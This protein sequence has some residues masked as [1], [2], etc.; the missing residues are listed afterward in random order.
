MIQV[1][2]ISALGC[3]FSSNRTRRR[4]DGRDAA[5]GLPGDPGPRHLDPHRR[6][7]GAPMSESPPRTAVIGAGISG[8][9]SGKM[10]KDYGVP[11][12]PR[13]SCPT[14]SAATGRSATRTASSAYRSL[15]IDTS[16]ERL[17]FR[18]FPIPEHFPSFPH[19]SDIKATRLLRRRL[20]PAGEHRVQQ[21]RAACRARP[22]GGGW[23]ITDQQ[24]R[25]RVRPAGRRQRP[26]L[27]RRRIPT[28]QAIHRRDHPLHHY[29]DPQ[30]PLDLTGKRI[31]VVG[32]GNSAADITVELSSK[33][34]QNTV[35]L[36]TR[37]SAWIVPEVHR[38]PA[39]RHRWRPRRTSRCPGSARPFS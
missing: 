24:V 12:T 39:R 7:V 23:E 22:D 30:T 33:T 13:S 14:A 35:T 3:A 21:R 31:L 8:L 19:H 25:P 20:R 17:S 37:S 34:L 27:G 28:S 16:K 6:R 2:L 32:I 4:H 38:R 11:G 1:P 5:S 29:I 36:S 10:L 18:T 9:T 15:H 26:P